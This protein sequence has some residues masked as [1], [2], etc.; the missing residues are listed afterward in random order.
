[1][2]KLS[3]KTLFLIA[4]V[5]ALIGPTLSFFSLQ[6]QGNYSEK[7]AITYA[8]STYIL[9]FLHLFIL[10]LVINEISNID[11]KSSLK[12]AIFAYY[13]MWIFD[14]VDIYQPLRP[15]SNVGL[16]ISFIVLYKLLKSD[17][18]RNKL[19]I[20]LMLHLVLYG[21]NA[22]IAESIATNPVLKKI[23]EV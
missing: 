4:L 9:D 15:L 3:L 16:L 8:I 7:V 5:L 13:P 19:I 6:S 10:G 11:L 12:I 20:L 2:Y 14:F 22:L 1:M 18:G 23:M 17:L 21:L